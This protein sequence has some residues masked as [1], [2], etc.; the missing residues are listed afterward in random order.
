KVGHATRSLDDC[1]RLSRAD[2]T[3]RTSILE[4]RHLS[5]DED[6]FDALGERFQL[7]VIKDTGPRFVEDKLAE[8]DLRHRRMGGS[9]YVLEPNI[10]DGKGGLRDLQTLF[11]IARDLYGARP[12]ALWDARENARMGIDYLERLIRRYQG[13]W[14]LALSHYNS[15]RGRAKLATRAYVDKVLRL[16]KYYRREAKAWA[17]ELKGGATDWPALHPNYGGVLRLA[18]LA[19][20]AD[21]GGRSDLDDFETAIEVRRR[22]ARPYLD[23]F[24]A[25]VRRRGG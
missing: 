14:D 2:V 21:R 1:V 19:R 4:A 17:G 3:I 22:L 18:A 23:D 7:E 9:R 5:G 13:R 20:D 10:K 12:D 25:V 15:A 24:A 8:R 11:W 16:Q 6:L